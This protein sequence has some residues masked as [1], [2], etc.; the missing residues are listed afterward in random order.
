ARLRSRM[1]AHKRM[2]GDQPELTQVVSSGI[3]SEPPDGL[4][5]K[6]VELGTGSESV[7]MY[8]DLFTGKL[9]ELP[10]NPDGRLLF[11]RNFAVLELGTGGQ[12]DPDRNLRV[13]FFAEGLERPIEQTLLAL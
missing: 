9:L 10:G 13:R 7:D 12:W 1:P 4:V 2:E 5:R 6:V 8:Q 3:G 11:R